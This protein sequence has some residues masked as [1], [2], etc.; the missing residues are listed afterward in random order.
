MMSYFKFFLVFFL[1]I[2]GCSTNY[3]PLVKNN[4][5]LTKRAQGEIKID[6]NHL[7]F[8]ERNNQYKYKILSTPN[9]LIFKKEKKFKSSFVDIQ[10][11]FDQEN[12]T[13]QIKEV[14]R[15]DKKSEF[16][17]TNNFE[18]SLFFLENI[19]KK[20]KLNV[21]KDGII[22]QNNNDEP[23]V[24]PY[25]IESINDSSFLLSSKGNNKLLEIWITKNKC[26]FKNSFSNYTSKVV[27]DN[28]TFNSCVF[29]GKKAIYN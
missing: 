19:D 7:Y 27:F 4:G 10:G 8:Q 3:H 15:A 23:I 1:L 13:L 17:K 9:N 11:I 20:I 28:M 6:N 16:Y 5:N 14:I 12:K 18:E 21:K 2:S 26:Y 25:I 22:I 29:I 24:L